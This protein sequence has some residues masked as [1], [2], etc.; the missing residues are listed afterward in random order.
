MDAPEGEDFR[1][2]TALRCVRNDRYWGECSER[3]GVEVCSCLKER[4]TLQLRVT[5]TPA[6]SHDGRGGRKGTKNGFRPP[7]E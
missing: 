6:L 3:Q 4:G 7:P 5:L 1:F 2:L